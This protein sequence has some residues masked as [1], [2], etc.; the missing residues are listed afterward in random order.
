MS[1]YIK[2]NISFF[3]NSTKSFN[4]HKCFLKV[5]VI[6]DKK[7]G[8]QNFFCVKQKRHINKEFLIIDF[9]VVFQ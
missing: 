5:F 1:F 7:Q 9:N 4:T 6:L 2:V 8:K 3:Q